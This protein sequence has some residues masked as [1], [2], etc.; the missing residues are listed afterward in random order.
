MAE[1]FILALDQGTTSSRAILFGHSGKILATAQQ[2]YRQI[3]PQPGWVE[4]DPEEI[5][6][7]QLQVAQ[8]VMKQSRT[9]PEQIV[10][11][12]ITNQ[13]ETT[14]LWDR[15]TGQA[16]HPAI[17]WQCRRSVGICED[18]KAAGH[19]QTL[20]HKTGLVVDAYFSGTKI[21]WILDQHPDLRQRAESGEL[22]AGTID[23]WLLYKLTG[24]AVHATEPSNA[25]RTMLYNLETGDWDPELLEIL[26]IPASLLPKIQSSSSLFGH[27]APE[28]FGG[29]SIP[30]TG[31]A[32]DQQAALFGQ[33]CFEP[34]MA[35]NT[36][37][38]GC[39]MLMNTGTEL[40]RSQHG[41]L[42]G[43]AWDLNGQRTFMLEGSV[44]MGGAIIQWLRDE[45]G[46][47]QQAS[48]S[49][50]LAMSVP[51][52]AG[53][54]IV[55]AFV[56]LGAPYWDAH[57]RG[58]ITGLTRGANKAHIT[59]AALEA[60]AYQSKDLLDAMGQD[61]GQPLQVLRV[62]G[63]ATSNQLLMQFQADILRLPVE[64][65]AVTETTALGAAY[66]AGLAVGY[67]PSPDTI[68][69]NWQLEKRFEA[70]MEAPQSQ[71]LYQGWQG[72]I[73]QSRSY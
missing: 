43:V 48:D 21:K 9:R 25:C 62:D 17:V 36:Y 40:V 45:L 73:Q 1:Q 24:G 60:I 49:E 37:G 31:M 5:W 16:V 22:M 19:E 29:H 53:V 7:T 58:T 65:P 54:Y 68:R 2:E 50:A 67:W 6:S 20:R 8:D 51:D 56:G 12:G 35:K 27:T 38:T 57:A 33:G 10:A 18:L 26:T 59:R 63:G 32:G 42:T 64:R 61:A 69:E 44:F 52:T 39:F 71:A 23:S 70:T 55:P 15:Q 13:R 30:I 72:A 34:G 47:I 28:L 66:L 11:I 14:V 4:H 41:L 3:Y 46:L